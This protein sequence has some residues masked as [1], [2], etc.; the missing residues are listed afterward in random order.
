VMDRGRLVQQGSPREIYL[1]P[2]SAFVAGFLGETNLLEGT[3]GQVEGD[4]VT[5][6]TPLGTVRGTAEAGTLAPGAAALCCIRPESVRI[7]AAGSNGP[8][9]FRGTVEREF[10]FGELRHLRV[11][12]GGAVLLSYRFPLQKD[13]FEPG[14]SV[15]FAI[16][17]ADVV[18]VPT[19]S[20]S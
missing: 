8:N 13:R 19:G 1:R 17:P 15:G 11:Q 18:V 12:S 5:V 6:T 3:V 16:D 2:Q 7:A 20:R 10:F 9:R 14:S 4:Q